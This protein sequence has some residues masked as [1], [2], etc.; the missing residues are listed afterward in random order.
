MAASAI[1][2][3]WSACV[4]WIEVS[5]L[6]DAQKPAVRSGSSI[7]GSA[8][9]WPSTVEPWPLPSERASWE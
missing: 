3:L 7:A 9:L 6:D 2:T 1:A 5:A 4:R 8:A